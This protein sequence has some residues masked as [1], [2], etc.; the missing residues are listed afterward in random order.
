MGPKVEACVR[1]ARAGGVGI[2]ANL[3]DVEPALAG[4]AGT[5]VVP[6]EG[7]YG[8]EGAPS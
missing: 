1:F 7:A 6:D 3:L 5:W 8:T 2:I 4:Q